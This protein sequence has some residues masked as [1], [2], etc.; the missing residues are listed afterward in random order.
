MVIDEA[1]QI[2]LLSNV[3]KDCNFDNIT[4]V[5]FNQWKKQTSKNAF[6]TRQVVLR[7]I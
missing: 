2:L 3:L 7:A 1:F 6:L 4:K 5:A